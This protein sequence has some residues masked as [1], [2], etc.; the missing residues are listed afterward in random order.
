MIGP[1]RLNKALAQAGI[2]S[3]RKAEELIAR[4]KVKVNGKLVKKQGVIIDP[5]KDIIEVSGNNISLL[6]EKKYYFLLNKPAGYVTTTSDPHHKKTVMNFLPKIKGL[7]PAGRLD[8][9]T[10]GLLLITNDGELTYRLTH[11]KFE[12]SKVYNAEVAGII[13]EP[14]LKRIEK[15][16]YFDGKRSVPCNA[17]VVKKVSNRT[18]V[19]LEIHEGRKRQVRRMFEAIGHKVL[20]LDRIEY[21][22]IKKDIK[23][24]SFRKLKD[25]EVKMLYNKARLK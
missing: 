11:P 24:G 22:R 5:L 8:K 7:F 14:E 2:A 15:G 18:I 6:A 23:I 20:K 4:S 12:I 21:G 25:T 13:S 10:T 1:I 19:Q 3:R 16:V 9:N 17:K